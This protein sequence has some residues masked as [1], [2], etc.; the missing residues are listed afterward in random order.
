MIKHRHRTGVQRLSRSGFADVCAFFDVDGTLW[1]EKSVLS[2]YERFLEHEFGEGAKQ[3]WAQFLDELKRLQDNNTPRD[4]LNEW[5]YG[6]YF[7]GV[8]VSR[9][10]G[11]ARAWWH[12]RVSR[13]DFWIEAVVRQAREHHRNG[14]ELVLVT[15]SF[16][17]VVDPLIDYLGASHALLTPLEEIEGIYTGRLNGAPMIGEGKGRAVAAYMRARGIDPKRSYGYGDDESDLPFLER[18][19]NPVVVVNGSSP[20]ARIARTRNWSVLQW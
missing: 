12:Q 18:V 2:F 4:R 6:K 14:H 15:G 16:R 1:N 17:E 20:L 11:V 3:A 8:A 5:F 19:A 9:I 13:S 10:A 7:C